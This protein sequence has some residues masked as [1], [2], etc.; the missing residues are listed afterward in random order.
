[1]LRVIY[2][3]STWNFVMIPLEQMYFFVAR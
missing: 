2:S 3:Y 1:M